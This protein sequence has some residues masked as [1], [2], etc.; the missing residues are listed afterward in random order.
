[1]SGRKSAEVNGLLTRG[2]NARDAGNVCYLNK[3]HQAEQAFQCNQAEISEIC[4]RLSERTFTVD[5]ECRKEF[6]N[7]AAMIE[8]ML[9]H[10]ENA[11]KG[12]SYQPV[13]REFQKKNNTIDMQLEYADKES[14]KIRERIKNKDWYCDDEYRDAGMLLSKYQK[15]AKEKSRL[16]VSIEQA[17]QDSGRDI[18]IYRNLEMQMHQVTEAYEKLQK[19]T[20]DI[21][22]LRNKAAKAKEY[23]RS[24][25]DE[26]E[27]ALAKKYMEEE[28]NSLL[29]QVKRFSELPDEEAVS[30]VTEISEIISLFLGKLSQRHTKFLEMQEKAI[31]ALKANEQLLSAEHNFYFEPADYFKNKENASKIPLL[32][33]LAEFTDKNEMIQSIE[34]GMET[35][36]QMIEGEKYED[37]LQQSERNLENIRR[38][39]D[40]ASLRQEHLIENFYVARDIKKVMIDMGFE[41]GA[42]K[43]GGQKDGWRITAKAPGGES[44][45]FSQVFIND[46]GKIKMDINHQTLG[47]CP[48]QWKEI[49][50]AFDNAGIYIEKIDMEDGTN[51]ISRKESAKGCQ[52]NHAQSHTNENRGVTSW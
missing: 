1:M 2:K 24:M 16:A 7:E 52:S 14:D 39:A 41:T 5:A 9:N 17:V 18:V 29:E 51:V 22:E 8:K 32:R 25:T 23:I 12:V 3:M 44:I 28:Y 21:I 38:A 4:R 15:I 31:A 37:A 26:A 48:S 11:N 35:I 47:N 33:Y 50:R 43:L 6:P 19:R 34:E 13:L 42:T 10:I 49:C 30:Q 45:D 40:Y 36:K 27:P 20:N 46:D